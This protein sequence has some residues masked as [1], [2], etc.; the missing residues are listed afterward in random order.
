MKKGHTTVNISNNN[1]APL[2][3]EQT[4]DLGA[5][6]LPAAGDN[7]GLVVQKAVGVG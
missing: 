6:A 4:R 2:V 1:L 7:G 3:R 5:D